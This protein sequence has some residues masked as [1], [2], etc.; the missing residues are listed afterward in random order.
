MG[1]F[2]SL[3]SAAVKVAVTPL[4]V[5]ADVGDVLEGEKP[6]NTKEVVGSALHDVADGVESLFDLD[7]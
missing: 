6:E 1:V 7:L 2:S 4:A 3:F 5:V